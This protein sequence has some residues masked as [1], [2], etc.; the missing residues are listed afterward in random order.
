MPNGFLADSV[1]TALAILYS[2]TTAAAVF[3]ELQDHLG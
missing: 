2:W 1:D 3:G